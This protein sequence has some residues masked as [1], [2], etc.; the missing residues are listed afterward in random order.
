MRS[1]LHACWWARAWLCGVEA[2]R[3]EGPHHRIRPAKRRMASALARRERSMAA[4][5]RS[6]AF[7]EDG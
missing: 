1:Y 3:H 5:V 6:A 2:A 7:G 4:L